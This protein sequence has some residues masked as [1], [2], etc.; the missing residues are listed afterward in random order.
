[1][2]RKSVEV[3]TADPA[4]S[5]ITRGGYA[6]PATGIEGSLAEVLAELVH[7]ERVS[8]DSHFFHD[9]GAN[10]LVMAHFCAQVR[11]RPGLPSVSM[12][13][14]Y[15]HPTIRS[16]AVALGEAVSAPVESSAPTQIELPAPASTPQYLLC[17]TLQ[18]LFFPGYVYLGT[19]IRKDSYF[20]GYRAH[21]GFIQTGTVTIGKNVVVSE[22]TVI[23]IETSMGDG[24]QLGDA[25]SLH[26][27]Q[28][29]P[30]GEQWHGI[31]GQRTEAD[32][33]G[34][35]AMYCGTARRAFYAIS[36]LLTVFI[37]YVPLGIG[38]PIV[39]SVKV[40]QL[41]DL[42]GDGVQASAGL[43]FYLD[44]PALSA[45]RFFG[46][47]ARR[48]R[49]RG[50]RPAHARSPAPA[51][52]LSAPVTVVVANDSST[53]EFPCRHRDWELP[54]EHVDLHALADGG[55]HFLRTRPTE[56]AR[57][58]LRAADLVASS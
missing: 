19:V 29:V 56:A 1:V 18:L 30:D 6:D 26:A 45:V 41:S 36:Q 9:L 5:S 17:A 33:L 43:T 2:V 39:L 13:D 54:A 27:G 22:A 38:G 25:S 21:A 42:M 48:P 58:V 16:L 11:K 55:H 37:V 50:H 49:R 15:R 47:G 31:P 34:V 3:L 44:L 32:F 14:S 7:V 46:L 10:S 12:K 28:A 52:R 40:P 20:N 24:A 8:A 51:V 57:A 23:D 53:A 4:E 35:D